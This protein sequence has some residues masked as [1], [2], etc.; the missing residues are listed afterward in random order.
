MAGNQ[1]TVYLDPAQMPNRTQDQQT[2]DNLWAAVLA[3][4][5][6]FGAQFNAGV[7]AFNAVAAGSAYAIPYTVDLSST[8][9]ADPTAG[10]LRFNAANQ[11]AATTLFADLLGSDTVDY[12]SILDQFDA[13]TSTV[14]GQI[15]IVK[16]GDP[17]KFLTFDVIARTVATGYRKL[18]VTNTGGSSANPF[19]ASDAVLIKFTRTGDVGSAG[20]LVRRTTSVASDAAPAP[21]LVS[22]DLYEIT[23]LAAN[24]ILQAPTG[25]PSNGQTLMFRIKDNGT[26][27][28]IAYTSVYRAP[29]EIPFPSTTVVGKWT[30]L[31]F[32][33]NG[34]DAKWDLLAAV[35]NM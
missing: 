25:T 6:T 18:V 21:S 10:K 11:N 30:Y 26:A 3:A 2:F 4:L 12:T 22:T 34:A 33:Y 8:A 16:Q 13:S 27:R 9:D 1:I 19:S 17:A 32:I 23:A 15:R 7:A 28:T 35:S 5:P 29:V 20:T 24:T 31:G 14:K